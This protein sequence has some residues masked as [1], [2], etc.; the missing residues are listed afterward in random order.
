MGVL[1]AG[2]DSFLEELGQVGWTSI[3]FCLVPV[4]FSTIAVY[5]L[6]NLFMSDIARR[7]AGRHVSAA[8]DDAEGGADARG[9]AVMI[10]VAVG[11][12][13][14][15]AAY[16][17]SG[18]SLAPVDL[19]AD[20]SEAVLYAL[21]FFVGISVGGSR[22]LL[23]KLR[24]YHVRVLIIP[25]GIVAGSVLG[26]LVCA[27]LAGMSLPT[28]AA[29]AS[30]LGWYSLAGVMMTDIAGAQ[31]G[32]IVPGEPAARARV[33]LQHPLDRQAFQLSHVHRAGRRYKRGHHAAHAHP[34]HERRDRRALGAERRHLLRAGPRAD[35]GVPS[36][37][38]G[39]GGFFVPECFARKHLFGN[40]CAFSG[41]LNAM[42]QMIDMQAENRHGLLG[43]DAPRLN[44][45]QREAVTATEG[46]VRV[47]A[48]AGTGKTR[49]LAHRFAYL[50]NELGIMPGN[51]LCATF[52]NKAAGEMRRRIR[53]L[54]GDNDTGYINTFHGFCVSVLQEDGHALQYPKSFL[55]LD[56]ADIDAMLQ[57]IYE[58]RGLTLR[59]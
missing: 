29:V 45:A 11:A 7:P 47:I 40:I 46:Y 15:G 56:N 9:E 14:L 8:Q 28:G 2:R 38:V 33:V 55:V 35:R 3:L 57:V 32:I 4:A 31:V 12:L 30:G 22:G 6:T 44:A 26:G 19:V 59:T 49:A 54:T 1:L 5:A 17:L 37:H 24:Q 21:M 27:P 16:G 20:H 51:V 52:T 25:A 43:D 39:S 10:G 41:I 48:G 13:A 42:E 36:I 50:V 34:L 53:R 18:V 58:E 23:G